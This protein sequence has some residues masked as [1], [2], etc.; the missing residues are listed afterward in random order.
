[1]IMPQKYCKEQRLIIFAVAAE[2]TLAGVATCVKGG[3][4]GW[5]FI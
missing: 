4:D 1:M 5:K 2:E 3:G